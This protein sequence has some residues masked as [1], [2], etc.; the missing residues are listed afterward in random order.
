MFVPGGW[1]HAVINLDNTIAITENVC[2]EGNFERVWVQ[3]RKNRKRLAYKWLRLIRHTES[4]HHI[5]RRALE[6]NCRDRFPMW[7]PNFKSKVVDKQEPDWTSSDDEKSISS[8]TSSDSSDVTSDDEMT[9][10][11]IRTGRQQI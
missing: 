1:W 11:E 5:Y 4:L 3:A 8:S 7:R 2:N 9:I 10:D 6:M